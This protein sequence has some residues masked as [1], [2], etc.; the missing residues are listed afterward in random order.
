MKVRLIKLD[1]SK[2]T[3]LI[4]VCEDKHMYDLFWCYNDTNKFRPDWMRIRGE[5][6]R[7]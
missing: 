1:R 3:I 7:I 2:L 4:R 5:W 6:R